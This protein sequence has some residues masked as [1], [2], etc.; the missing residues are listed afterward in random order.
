MANIDWEKSVQKSMELEKS[1]QDLGGRI[2]SKTIGILNKYKISE[3]QYNRQIGT[4]INK[5][6][7]DCNK[8]NVLDRNLCLI[9][10]LKEVITKTGVSLEQIKNA[11]FWI[12]LLDE[13]NNEYYSP[14][15]EEINR[16]KTLINY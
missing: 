4:W 3:E 12:N 8:T 2:P 14:L 1:I 5:I 10:K 9:K 15:N 13:M 7:I 11:K 16:M 6:Y